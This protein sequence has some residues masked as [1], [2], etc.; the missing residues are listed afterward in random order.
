[1]KELL[2]E[3]KKAYN[4]YS[5]MHAGHFAPGV[6]MKYAETK[7]GYWY[8]KGYRLNTFVNYLDK[9]KREKYDS[10]H[11]RQTIKE[12]EK[13]RQRGMLK[14]QEKQRKKNLEKL[15]AGTLY[16]KD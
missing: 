5:G 11:K 1:M 4:T 3:F 8:W 10:K 15:K 7:D 2:K 12:W 16:P 9:L 6:I 13:I 14:F